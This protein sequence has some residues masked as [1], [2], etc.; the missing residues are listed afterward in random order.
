MYLD[1]N[2]NDKFVTKKV[3]RKVNP[4]LQFVYG[5]KNYVTPRLK[6]LLGTALI[7]PYFYHGCT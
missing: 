3:F 6:R 7:Q 2:V 4:K 5:Q 1:S